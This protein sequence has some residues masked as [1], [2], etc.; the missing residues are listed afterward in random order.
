VRLTVTGHLDIARIICAR[1]KDVHINLDPLVASPVD[2]QDST[3][4]GINFQCKDLKTIKGVFDTATDDLGR[5][6]FYYNGQYSSGN[7]LRELI[8]NAPDLM[9]ISFAATD[10]YGYREIRD[11]PML[12]SLSSFR[13]VMP[14]RSLSSRFG[15]E[16]EQTVSFD[17]TSLHAALAEKICNVHLDQMGF[18]LRGPY[19]V[20]LSP[21]FPQHLVNELGW[22]TDLAPFL[23]LKIGKLLKLS[24]IL[25]T[26]EDAEKFAEWITKN[27]NLELPNFRNGYR[28]G[29]GISVNA[30]PNLTIS[31]KYTAKCGF[32]QER[33]GDLD[34]PAPDG[35][36]IGVGITYRFGG[37]KKKHR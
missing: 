3:L 16:D 6:A 15:F 30:T 35:S 20:F 26:D 34:I 4:K 22:Q 9:D 29:V 13:P 37:E 10:G 32:C 36:S 2:A 28:P 21:D 19:G 25:R 5:R 8:R 33:Q 17:V 11:M 1:L 18:V 23:G 24:N 12:P 27:V 14:N 7:I 31:A